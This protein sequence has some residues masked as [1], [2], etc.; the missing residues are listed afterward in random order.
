MLQFSCLACWFLFVPN[1][2]RPKIYE[3]KMEVCKKINRAGKKKKQSSA[4]HICN[5]FLGFSLIFA[6]ILKKTDTAGS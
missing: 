3:I 4:R 5:N 6:L 2:Q 1:L